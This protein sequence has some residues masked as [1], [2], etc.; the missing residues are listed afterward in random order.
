[1]MDPVTP[2]GCRTSTRTRTG[3]RTSTGTRMDPRTAA[4][5]RTLGGILLVAGML[6]SMVTS[7]S[8][9]AGVLDL[10]RTAESSP[11]SPSP[12]AGPPAPS[13]LS[14]SGYHGAPGGAG[15]AEDSDPGAQGI[16]LLLRPPDLLS[17]SLPP[18]LPPHPQP[19]LTPPPPWEQGPSLEEAWGSG[20]YLETL[21][22]MVPDGEELAL[23][24]P[25]PYDQD[26]AGGDWVSYDTAFPA[27]PTVPLS[28]RLQ[29]SPS[30]SSTP[31]VPL[32]T[33]PAHADV[34]PTW[35]EDY[36]LE[37]MMPLEP[38]ELLLP[39]MNS[40]EYYTNLLA[41]ERDRDKD[42]D[43]GKDQDRIKDRTDSKPPISPTATQS[44]RPPSTPSPSSGPPEG[45][46]TPPLT[47]SPS[48]TGDQKPPPPPPPPSP[49]RTAPAPEPPP[50]HVATTAG[51]PPPPRPPSNATTG[52][53]PPPPPLGPPTR[54]DRPER[55][56]P[57]VTDKPVKAPPPR[58]TAAA[59]TTTTTTTTQITAISLTRAP[60]VTTPKVAQAPPTRQYL[61]NITR[62]EMYLVRV[63]SSKGSSAGF[64]Q[65]RDLLKREFNRSVEL[66]FLRTPSSFAFRVV[67]G[68]LIFTS[69]SVINALRRAPRGFGPVP[70][71]TPLYTVPDLRYQVH[72]VLQ[73]VPAHVD[74]RLCNFSERIE[75]G[76]LM[77]YGETRKRSHEAGNVTVQ[78]LNITMPVSRLLATAAAAAGKKVSV[79][80]T[81]AVR[82]GGRDFLPG[83]EVSEHLRRLSLVEFSFYLGFPALQVAE[84]FHYPELN[85]SHHLRSTWVR[86]VLLGVQDQLVSERSFKARLERRL[87]LLLEEGQ[88]TTSR[89][90]QRR[91]TA[92]G[93]HS[94]QVVRV[95]RLAGPER[96]L[97]VFYFVEGPGGERVP[98]EQTAETLNRL[99]LQRAAIVLGHRVHRPIAQ[100]VETLSVPPAETQ[101]SSV[102]LIVG[103]VVPV[104]LALF[105]I[106]ILYWK[107]CGSE[108]LEF[109]PDAINTIQQRQKLQAPSVKGFDFA[110][111]HLGQHSKDDIMVIQEPGPL[112]APVKEATPSDGGDLNTP[113]SKGSSTKVTRSSRRR[114]RLSPSDGD[115]LGSDQSSGRE[116]AEENTRPV[117]TPSEGKQ[118]RKTPKNGRN[119]MG[120]GP[121]EL[122]SSS[123]IFDHVDRLSR[124]SSD[125]TRRQANKVQLIA[126]QPR[127][128]PPPLHA[129]P[130]LSPT[131]T[132]KVSTEVALRHKSEI[133]HH[134]NKLR[135]R[136]KRRGQCEF[137]SMD[138]IMDAF[139]DGPV[140]SEVA[141]RLYSSAHD[142]MD[143]ILQS[144]A[145]SPPT[146]TDSRRRGRRSP[147]GRRAQPGPGSLPDTDRDRLLTDHSA[148]YRKYPGL[149]NV[150]YMSDPDLPPDH[151]SPSPTDEVFD[152]A[153]APPPYMPPQP[154]I[155]E[156]RQQMHSLLDDAFALV[157]PSSQGSAG[158][159]GV[160]P[161]LPS[162]SPQTRPPGRQ[163]GSYPAAPSHSPFSARYAELGMSPTSVQGLL[164]RQGLN[165]GGY[166]S[167]G[168]QLQE[169]VYSSRGQYEDPP[170]SSRPRPVG[171]STGAQLHHLTQVGLSSQIGAYPGVGRSM[172]GPTG[173][174]W[175]QQ[176]SDQ[177]L[178]RPGASRESV[179][180][181]PEFSSSSVFQMPSSSLRDPSAPPLLLTSPTPEYPPE[182]ASPSAHTSASLIKAIREELRRLAQKQ[183]AVTSYP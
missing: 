125:G 39:D 123:S 160:S 70:V 21:S 79:D 50:D 103:V 114:G 118:H 96:P 28:S 179:L 4:C 38:T 32:H 129:P 140:Q 8:P 165:S 153:P 72:S 18:P 1:M 110:K 95:A 163:W 119:K 78:L 94:L 14:D 17:P 10:N 52:R 101:S 22:F 135:Q 74:V 6:V 92:V 85:T 25:L 42:Q 169:S 71:V 51:R 34:F 156:A 139:G 29:L 100:P 90:R 133:E 82:E 23:A 44:H 183:A 12:A 138:D 93:D 177:D 106:I 27:R 128:S 65:V 76:L 13:P 15:S 57:P 157:S 166:V 170:S 141:Q 105:I 64:T 164:Q 161:A 181:F 19:T 151:G 48:L 7:S 172:S 126:M 180:S 3:T 88:Q 35:D 108:K 37:D 2:P 26:T 33:R 46:A 162:P 83:S 127:P 81:F 62:P 66:Q 68:S 47:L 24:T 124:G 154:S 116:S 111:L 109:Q 142:H 59:T 102:W 31:G 5:R 43:R 98:A 117:A 61:C 45:G 159:S 54:P 87:A 136:A 67:S 152:S 144:D 20:D 137:P 147:R 56:P 40:M 86:T 130:Q 99:D 176:H 171:G 155:E 113:K 55:P 120:S 122:L 104:L 89:R 143:C 84:P 132:E 115:S 75:R 146:P 167:T 41:R 174:S 69:M 49:T 178:S 9:A 60:P 11:P 80:V 158:V 149:N 148:T 77:A 58:T 134:R 36:D 16:H 175:N 173:S 30:S 182:D 112:P 53:V 97:E 168:D 150:A 121:D 73:F 145:H 107:L 63:V 131:L 91:A